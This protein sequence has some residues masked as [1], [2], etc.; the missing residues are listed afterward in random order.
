[1]SPDNTPWS[2]LRLNDDQSV[3]QFSYNFQNI[4]STEQSFGRNE[5]QSQR[6]QMQGSNGV[7]TNLYNDSSNQNAQN[8]LSSRENPSHIEQNNF[9]LPNNQ[10]RVITSQNIGQ[11]YGYSIPY[12]QSDGNNIKSLFYHTSFNNSQNIIHQFPISG[13]KQIP[14]EPVNNIRNDIGPKVSDQNY[15]G[16]SNRTNENSEDYSMLRTKTSTEPDSASGYNS[17][18]P[19]HETKENND[20]SDGSDSESS[21][22]RY[23]FNYNRF[24]KHVREHE[25]IWNRDNEGYNNKELRKQAWLDILNRMDEEEESRWHKDNFKKYHAR[26]K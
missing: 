12:G 26:G 11:N 19:L 17:N 9:Y 10:T 7:P 25:C 13:K 1:M 2:N 3:K 16:N 15:N 24:I 23:S 6:I 21:I 18:T 20:I 8:F 14:S 5:V 4:N 22:D